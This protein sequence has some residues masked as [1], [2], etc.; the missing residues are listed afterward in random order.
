MEVLTKRERRASRGLGG[1]AENAERGKRGIRAENAR[2][3]NLHLS[4]VL[5]RAARLR[6]AAERVHRAKV[7]LSEAPV[8]HATI[9]KD[10]KMIQSCLPREGRF[11]EV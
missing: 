1:G 7:S 8:M 10:Q 6:P 5:I 3:G 9:S 11:Y 2:I 4:S